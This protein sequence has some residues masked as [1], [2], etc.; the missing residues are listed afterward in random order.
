[1]KFLLLVISFLFHLGSNAQVVPFTSPDPIP[2]K[3]GYKLVWADEF[4]QEGVPDHRF[5]S[6][7]HGFQRNRE[8]QWYQTENARVAEGYLIIEGRRERVR[9][10]AFAKGSK[11]W[12]ESRSH[13][14]YTSSSINTNGK[15]SFQY[16]MMEVRAKIDTAK[17]LWPAIWTLGIAGAWPANGEIDVMEYYL[18][19]GQPTILANTAW[20]HAEKRASWDEAKLPFADLLAKDPKW[21][22]KFHIWKLDWTESYIRIYLDEL[23][24]NEVDLQQTVNPDGTNPFHQPHYI[25]LNLAIGS[26]G[27]DPTDSTFPSHYVVDYVRVYQRK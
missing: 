16:G 27:G 5:W 1:M 13:A 7:E 20:A 11:D 26:N 17:G 19:D 25:L 6:F 18:S 3:P 21:S 8:L 14:T 23:L 15:F 9:N 12:K 2:D 24:L 10:P 22:E 4:S